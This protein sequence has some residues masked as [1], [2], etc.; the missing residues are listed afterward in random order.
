M[1]WV[2]VVQHDLTNREI[3]LAEGEP[4][5]RHR[6]EKVFQCRA[7]P[8][9]RQCRCHPWK[10]FGFAWFN[11]TLPIVRSSVSA[12]NARPPSATASSSLSQPPALS[13][14]PRRRRGRR[15]RPAPSHTAKRRCTKTSR[16]GGASRLPTSLRS[17]PS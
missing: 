2:C 1:F 17:R 9:A 8:H 11:S 7:R 12:I 6:Q 4:F 14:T 13:C 15:G 10:C 3:E 5:L 16:R